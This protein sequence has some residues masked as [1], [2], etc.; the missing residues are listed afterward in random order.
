MIPVFN[1]NND[2]L[3]IVGNLDI[4]AFM[5][6]STGETYKQYKD[7][8]HLVIV[9]LEH[10]QVGI[11]HMHIGF[12]SNLSHHATHG[13]WSKGLDGCIITLLDRDDNSWRL[14]VNGFVIAVIIVGVISCLFYCKRV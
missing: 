10:D 12:W 8:L 14:S 13:S 11:P 4:T 2:L 7:T 9:V 6:H 1:D 5:A 3:S